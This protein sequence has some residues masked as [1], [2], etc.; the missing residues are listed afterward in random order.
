MSLIL[1]TA[2]ATEPISLDEVKSHLRVTSDQDDL[3]LDGLIRAARQ[4]VEGRDGW[5]GRTLV[6][7]TW[8][9]KLE[10]FPSGEDFPNDAWPRAVAIR[11]PLPPLQ[12]ITSVK[13]LDTAGVEQ[14]ITSTEYVVHVS[15]EPGLIVPAYGKTWPSIRLEPGAVRIRFVAGYGATADLVPE[16]LKL[17]L[18]AF[19]A[20]FYEQR[21]PVVLTGGVG[22]PIPIPMH[23]EALLMPY[24]VAWSF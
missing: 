19:V 10:R 23:V 14:T 9:L 3:L 17:A 13:Y 2:P 20:H 11:V 15:E 4:H 21:E 12:T 5:L 1:V 18:K 6:T 22:S 24:R 8:D 16:P 7:Q